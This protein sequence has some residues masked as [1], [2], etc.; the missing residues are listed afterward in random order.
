MAKIQNFDL[1]KQ[2]TLAVTMILL[3]GLVVVVV[4]HNRIKDGAKE[5]FTLAHIRYG[6]STLNAEA[7]QRAHHQKRHHELQNDPLKI[8]AH[9]NLDKPIPY[10]ILTIPNVFT[11]EECAQIIQHLSS[12]NNNNN[13]KRAFTIMPNDPTLGQYARKL[14]S[15]ASMLT[16]IQDQSM[17]ES[18]SVTRYNK[19]QYE[20]VHH[21]ACT[22]NLRCKG[23]DRVYRRA[24][25]MLYLNDNYVGGDLKFPHLNIKVKPE[26]GKCTFFYNVNAKGW[27]IMEAQHDS[28]PVQEGVKW[29]C[30]LWIKFKPTLGM[31]KVLESANPDLS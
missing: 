2:M 6:P 11:K 17:Y 12:N 15:F 25:I 16:G 22:S 27:E 20:K 7:I 3:V 28:L 8:Q 1:K 14:M 9:Y 5:N 18:L 21:D 31:I 10:Q 29:M 24:T 26:T 4:H 30:T 19:D 13:G 23:N